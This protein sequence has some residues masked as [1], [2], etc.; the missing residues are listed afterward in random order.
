MSSGIDGN[1][2]VDLAGS[3]YSPLPDEPPKSTQSGRWSISSV[4]STSSTEGLTDSTA[5]TTSQSSHK[6][7]TEVKVVDPEPRLSEKATPRQNSVTPSITSSSSTQFHSTDITEDSDPVKPI[8]FYHGGSIP[9]TLK[10]GKRPLIGFEINR[11]DSLDELKSLKKHVRENSPE[12]FAKLH[13]RFERKQ[14]SLVLGTSQRRSKRLMKAI[15][16]GEPR[17]VKACLKS[18]KHPPALAHME[19]VVRT[20]NP[21]LAS[22]LKDT[23]SECFI[24]VHTS[25]LVKKHMGG[26]PSGEPNRATV[27][28]GVGLAQCSMAELASQAVK[29]NID[30]QS[31]FMQNVFGAYK[32]RTY[33]ESWKHDFAQ[34]NEEY[35]R[36]V[37][38][39][40]DRVTRRLE[41][42]MRVYIRQ[43]H[44]ARPDLVDRGGSH[45]RVNS[46]D[47]TEK[48]L[49]SYI[50]E[51]EMKRA[52]GSLRASAETEREPRT[53]KAV[54]K[55]QADE[56]LSSEERSIQIRQLQ[57]KLKSEIDELTAVCSQKTRECIAR[58]ANEEARAEYMRKKGIEESEV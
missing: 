41:A 12:A 10:M 7:S 25:Q 28:I 51:K 17:A 16:R 50:D 34:T 39:I 35:D 2:P 33:D 48:F 13:D 20:R 54:A 36:L 27:Y 55:L 53:R 21:G 47:D 24:N 46:T 56:T 22:Q 37:E 58:F 18:I 8:S 49:D 45:S 3:S 9:W 44:K 29:A 30:N 6:T 57:E 52:V 5:G 15:D 42:E 14:L 4:D 19:H 31:E 43:I 40:N 1:G 38:E 32:N 23:L 11:C 26:I